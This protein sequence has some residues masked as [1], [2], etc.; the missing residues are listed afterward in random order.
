MNYH[1]IYNHRWHNQKVKPYNSPIEGL[2]VIAVEHIKKGE[3]IFVYGGV[4][5]PKAEIK[6]YHENLG[7]VGIQIDDNFWICPT[8]REELEKQG[9]INHSCEPNTGFQ[10]QI[11]LVAIKDIEPN[12]EITFDYAFSESFMDEFQCNCGSPQCRKVISQD[13]WKSKNLKEKY[14]G[15]FS[16]YLKNK[17]KNL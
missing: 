6:D 4:I 8:S 3:V 15:Y 17:I 11:I 1:S 16:P 13:D 2:G 12:K 5:V 10:N 14:G 7:D 9:V